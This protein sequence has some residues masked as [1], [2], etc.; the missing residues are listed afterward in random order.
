MAADKPS[1]GQLN[2]QMAKKTKNK[3][4]SA[5]QNQDIY[6]ISWLFIQKFYLQFKPNIHQIVKT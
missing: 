3:E 4:T 1:I 2:M 5:I 6:I